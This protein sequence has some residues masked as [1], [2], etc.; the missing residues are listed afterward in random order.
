[1]NEPNLSSLKTRLDTVRGHIDF[2]R[3]I[4]IDIENYRI[5]DAAYNICDFDF[6]VKYESH[7]RWS[8]RLDRVRNNLMQQVFTLQEEFIKSSSGNRVG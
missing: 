5:S 1:M 8:K 7:D 3:Q 2:L 6:F 4:K